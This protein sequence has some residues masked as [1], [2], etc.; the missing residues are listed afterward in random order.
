MKKKRNKVYF[1]ARPLAGAKLTWSHRTKIPS[2]I[3]LYKKSNLIVF[4]GPRMLRDDE[5]L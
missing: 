3:R 1:L 5:I 4:K 2:I